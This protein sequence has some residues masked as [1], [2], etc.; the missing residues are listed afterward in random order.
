MR[1]IALVALGLPLLAT[2]HTASAEPTSLR[3]STPEPTYDIGFRIG[4]Y[5]F[6]REG[7]SADW[8]ECRMNGVGLFATRALPGPLFMEAGLDA[9]TSAGEAQVGDL[10]I[11]RMSGLVSVAIGARTNVTSWLR[12]YLQLGGGLELSR[13]SVPYGEHETIRDD[14]VMPE[15]FFGVGLDFKIARGTYLGAT[16]RTHV[17]GN[18]EY[19]PGDVEMNKWVGSPA[20]AT[21]FDPSPVFAAQGQ[22]YVRRDL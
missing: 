4:G 2:A 22:F 10:P 1:P 13:V 3:A 14:K 16:M 17:M 6:R 7:A 5:G 15:A 11:D 12:G 20:A 18:F 19:Q 21:V 8:T 9:Y